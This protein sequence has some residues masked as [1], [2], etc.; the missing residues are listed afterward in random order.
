[1]ALLFKRCHLQ[2]QQELPSPGVPESWAVVEISNTTPNALMFSALDPG[3]LPLQKPKSSASYTTLRTA[4]NAHSGLCP[5]QLSEGLGHGPGLRTLTHPTGMSEQVEQRST[6]RG[7]R[8]R[9][10]GWTCRAPH[11]LPPGGVA[12]WCPTTARKG[13]QESSR[14]TT[15]PNPRRTGTQEAAP[16]AGQGT[17]RLGRASAETGSQGAPSFPAHPLAPCLKSGNTAQCG[18]QAEQLAPPIYNGRS[19]EPPHPQL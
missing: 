15:A 3:L 5:L 9:T 7:R 18:V 19:G 6:R 2:K 4:R 14:V 11:P 17:H 12:S 8:L 13:P 16:G 10:P 1:M